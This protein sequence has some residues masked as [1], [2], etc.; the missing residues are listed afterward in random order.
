MTEHDDLVLLE[1]DLERV[2]VAGAVVG[3]LFSARIFQEKTSG[4]SKRVSRKRRPWGKSRSAFVAV[5][6]EDEAGG[7]RLVVQPDGD[8]QFEGQFGGL[9]WWQAERAAAEALA[10]PLDQNAAR[11]LPPRRAEERLPVFGSSAPMV[12]QRAI[13]TGLGFSSSG[14]SALTRHGET[15]V[16][17]HS[18]FMVTMPWTRPC[19]SRTGPPLLPGSIGMASWIICWPSI[20][21]VPETTPATTLCSQAERIA[22]GDDRLALA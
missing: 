12:S 13:G 21:R 18:D 1:A 2:P 9:G 10:G 7:A 20:S 5:G 22:E 16:A 19:R 11:A 15:E 8:G 17:W 6:G 3:R 4:P 14:L